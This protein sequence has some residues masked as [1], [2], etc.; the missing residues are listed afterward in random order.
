ME[1]GP[2][3]GPGDGGGARSRHRPCPS[4][5]P[6]RWRSRQA[7][8]FLALL[9]GRSAG[10]AMHS[11]LGLL[12]VFAGSTFA[13]YLLSTR[14]PHASTLVSAE[15]AG[16]RCVAAVTGSEVRVRG[17]EPGPRMRS[18]N[19]RFGF[20]DRRRRRPG[21]EAQSWA[22]R[23]SWSRDLALAGICSLPAARECGLVPSGFV[24]FF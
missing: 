15:E 13:L 20:P 8:R 12:L 11:L 6:L 17:R 9:P 22:G 14:L 24:F 19:R 2:G 7:A 16:D 5:N 4:A 18:G 10:A 3:V 1:S 23:V 21:F